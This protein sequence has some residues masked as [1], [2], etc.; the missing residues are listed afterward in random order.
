MP[1]P[2]STRLYIYNMHLRYTAS[3]EE[4]SGGEDTW[5]LTI[6]NVSTKDSGV[7]ECQV[8]IQLCICRD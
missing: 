3:Q 7:F 8:I 4:D 5:V 6:R 2:P 1:I